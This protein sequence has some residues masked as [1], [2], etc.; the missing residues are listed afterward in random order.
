MTRS[1]SEPRPEREGDDDKLNFDDRVLL[2]TEA[3]DGA[4]PV[5][6]LSLLALASGWALSEV[7]AD[8]RVA[9]RDGFIK[10]IDDTARD[11]R[12]RACDA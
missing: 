3:L 11:A 8:Q 5:E 12:I 4:T 9:A 1:T 6:C 10:L 2:I 7:S